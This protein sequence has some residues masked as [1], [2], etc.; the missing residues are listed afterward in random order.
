M[1]GARLEEEVWD[2]YANNRDLL[3]HES[4]L[5][6]EHIRTDSSSAS[7]SVL[8]DLESDEKLESEGDP[9][10]YAHRSYERKSGNRKKKIDSIKN[11]GL[12]IVCECCSF[13]FEKTYGE[14][15]GTSSKYTTLSLCQSSQLVKNFE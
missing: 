15:G 6:A 5:L 13:D 11:R 1:N 8:P 4:A 2:S 10:T 12:P 3:C 9:R 7:L 14:R